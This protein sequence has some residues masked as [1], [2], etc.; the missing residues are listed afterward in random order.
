MK[1]LNLTQHPATEEQIAAG[2][3]D[4]SPDDRALLAR[5]LTFD[6][7]PDEATLV[8]RAQSI[9]L[10]AAGHSSGARSVMIGGA[11][12][13]MRPLEQ[14]LWAENIRPLYAFSVRESIEHVRP[15]GAVE[16]IAVFRHTGFVGM[17]F[18]ELAANPRGARWQRRA[19]KS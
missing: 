4:L 12:Y 11:P 6:E 7:A 17:E 5:A 3:I 14:A 19:R 15:S 10:M 13:F 16:K 18:T 8:A 2:V 1:I 9:A